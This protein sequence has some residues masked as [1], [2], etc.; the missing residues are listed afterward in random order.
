MTQTW[1][2]ETMVG[3]KVGE[4][5]R[6]GWAFAISSKERVL[7]ASLSPG[8]YWSKADAMSAIGLNLKGRCEDGGVE[9]PKRAAIE[10]PQ[11]AF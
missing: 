6:N 4:I 9:R 1:D 2:V 10:A 8:P 5:T 7:F 3:N 11:S